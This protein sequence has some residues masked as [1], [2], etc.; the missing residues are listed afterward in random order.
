MRL[1][2][3][4]V[5]A[6]DFETTGQVKGQQNLPWQIGMV[7]MRKGKVVSEEGF[8]RYLRVPA[9][10]HF[11]PYTPGRWAEMREE[12][13]QCNSLVQE[14]PEVSTW[15]EGAVLVAHN[16]PTERKMLR[17]AFPM[18]EFGPWID[19]LRIA[20]LTY[21]LES[22]ALSDLLETL[23]LKQRVDEICHGLAPHDAFYDAVGCACL[24][25][26]LCTTNWG[27]WSVELLSRV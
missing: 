3:A 15:L 24:L 1:E 16:V 2:D 27:E 13:A 20:R 18:H 6:L 14:W 21:K 7:R 4:K 17:Q 12:L 10:Y 19:T 5:V 26:H 25:E 23:S 9:D 8:S 11:S 22:Y